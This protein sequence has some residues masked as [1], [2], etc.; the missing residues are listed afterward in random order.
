[1]YICEYRVCAIDYI[2]SSTYRKKILHYI[3]YSILDY[4]IAIIFNYSRFVPHANN[5]KFY[6]QVNF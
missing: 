1:M 5:E 3:F 4:F 6:L 2:W